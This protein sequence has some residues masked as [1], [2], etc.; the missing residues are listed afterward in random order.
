MRRIISVPVIAL[1]LF[2]S[3]CQ[4]APAASATPIPPADTLAPTPTAIPPTDTLLPTPTPPTPTATATPTVSP[5]ASITPIPTAFTPFNAVTTA[6]E[7]RL[8]T[9]PGYLFPVFRQIAEG[10]TVTVLGK[11]PGGEWIRVRTKETV[12]GWVFWRL[13]RATVDV[14]EAPVVQPQNV[15]LIQGRVLDAGGTPIQGVSFDVVQGDQ[16]VSGTNPVL[17]D[18]SGEFFAF[19]PPSST[20]TWTVSQTGIDCD[21]NVW[22]DASCT[23]YKNG[24]QG[25]VDPPSVDVTLPSTGVLEFTWK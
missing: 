11:A 1:M 2:L 18:S 4:T 5:T 10:G 8:R 22:T 23:N 7:V 24:Y 9:G 19:L 21:S 6:A 3:A 13:L 20:G 12:E 15:Q 25:T 16:T 14:E 17:T